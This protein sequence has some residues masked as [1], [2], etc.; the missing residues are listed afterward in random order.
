MEP[1]RPLCFSTSTEYG[2][3]KDPQNATRTRQDWT[4]RNKESEREKE[5]QT[6]KSLMQSSKHTNKGKEQNSV[7]C[8]VCFYVSLCVCVSVCV[9][10]CVCLCPRGFNERETATQSLIHPLFPDTRTRKTHLKNSTL[11]STT[12]DLASLQVT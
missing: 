4:V 9:C 2:G 10:V 8:T 12:T 1:E 7:Q 5:R 3:R 6:A 11:S